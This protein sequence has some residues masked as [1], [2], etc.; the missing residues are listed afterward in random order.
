[1]KIESGNFLTVTEQS[2]VTDTFR[3]VLDAGYHSRL[4]IILQILLHVFRDM[5][6]DVP[7]IFL[8]GLLM[9]GLFLCTDRI[10]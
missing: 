10:K 7:V 4:Y 1:V 5:S 9:A 3:N 8:E 2:Q 6:P